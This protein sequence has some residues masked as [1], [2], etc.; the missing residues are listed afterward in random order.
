MDLDDFRKRVQRD[1]YKRHQYWFVGAAAGILAVIVFESAYFL[2]V[3]GA[4]L[5][6][7]GLAAIRGGKSAVTGI[8]VAAS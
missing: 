4:S 1:D 6:G 2:L 8:G 7:S 5:I 3:T